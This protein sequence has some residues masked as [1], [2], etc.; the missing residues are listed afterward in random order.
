MFKMWARSTDTSQKQRR[1]KET[2]HRGVGIQTLFVATAY[3]IGEVANPTNGTAMPLQVLV[4]EVRVV[5]VQRITSNL[6]AFCK[7]QP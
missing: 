4:H 5:H 2:A 6:S 3:G 7:R 1:H